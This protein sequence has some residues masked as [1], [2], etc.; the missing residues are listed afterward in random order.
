M[1]KTNDKEMAPVKGI[2]ELGRATTETKGSN[3][4]SF[5][6]IEAQ[7]LPPVGLSND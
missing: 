5:D 1:T 4:Q 7:Q 2:I 3:Q 6:G